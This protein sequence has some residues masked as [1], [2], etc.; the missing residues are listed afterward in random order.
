M[1]LQGSIS[2]QH[3][4]SVNGGCV[5]LPMFVCDG[6]TRQTLA[7]RIRLVV[8]AVI[9]IAITTSFSQEGQST[10]VLFKT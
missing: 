9:L 8:S 3:A 1:N 5:N 7:Y 4:C 6:A 2:L 10:G